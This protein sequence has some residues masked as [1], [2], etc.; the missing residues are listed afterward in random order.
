[1]NKEAYEMKR[2]IKGYKNQ[3]QEI[4][5]KNNFEEGKQTNNDK[6][7]REKERSR[8]IKNEEEYHSGKDS[9]SIGGRTSNRY[10]YMEDNIDSDRRGENMEEWRKNRGR[11]RTPATRPHRNNY[12]NNSDRNNDRYRNRAQHQKNTNNRFEVIALHT[13]AD[14]TISYA[15]ALR[16]AKEKIDIE[17]LGIKEANMRRARNGGLIIQIAGQNNRNKAD[18]LANKMKEIFM[19]GG[20]QVSRPRRK[21]D[22]LIIGLDEDITSEDVKQSVARLDESDPSRVQTGV[23]KRTSFGRQNIRVSCSAVAANRMIE[24]GG[25]KI[26]WSRARVVILRTKKIQCYRCLEFGHVRLACTNSRDRSDLCYK[27]EKK[28]HRAA[29]C[30]NKPECIVCKEKGRNSQHRM[31]GIT[32]PVVQ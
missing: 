17:E 29:E 9:V 8:R 5:R 2:R 3:L 19:G 22:T 18:T 23:M 32:V 27:C 14:D 20:V 15:D 4:K 28:G 26:G 10:N 30:G 31:G 7:Y 1:M 12:Y 25:L 11:M 16:K 13:G 6:V 21:G 24:Q